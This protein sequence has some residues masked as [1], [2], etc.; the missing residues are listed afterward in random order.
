MT[1]PALISVS[2]P[3]IPYVP[4]WVLVCYDFASTGATSPVILELTFPGTGFGYRT[5]VS[6]E[7][8]CVRVY[9]PAGATGLYVVDASAQ[10]QD[11]G[12]LVEPD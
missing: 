11:G 4:H 7:E 8:P 5:E 12:A 9:V 6:K 3:Q 1:L 2:P 10:S